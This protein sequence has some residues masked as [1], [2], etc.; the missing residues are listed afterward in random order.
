M[1]FGLSFSYIFEDDDW[2]KKIGIMAL[3]TLI[4]VI[5][6]FVLSGWGA[7]IIRRVVRSS[8]T[9][10]PDLDFGKQLGDGFKIFVIGIVYSLPMIIIILLLGL[11]L[12][13]IQDVSQYDT[14]NMITIIG[15]LLSLCFGII[16]IIYNILITFLLPAAYANFAMKGKI[17]D[18]LRFGEVFRLFKN[19]LSAYL[20]IFL[21]AILAG[22]VAS[23]GSFACGIGLL[24]TT[25]YAN[26]IMMHLYGQAYK[27]SQKV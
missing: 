26:T 18:G 10:L 11:G 19:N 21:G 16:I 4:P 3:V 6:L 12:F 24:L 5:G 25:V 14:R 8:D 9:P 15:I 27:I 20:I 1:D 22:I 2:F 17:S 13:S 23:I 7:E